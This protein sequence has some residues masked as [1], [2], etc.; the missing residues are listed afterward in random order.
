ME[1]DSDNSSVGSEDSLADPDS[2]DNAVRSIFASYYG[3]E[4]EQQQQQQ[5]GRA[6]NGAAAAADINSV[7][8]DADAYSKSLLQNAPIE[9]LLSRDTKMTHEIRALDSDMQMLVYENYN[10]FI[11]ATETIKRMKSNV[12]AMD[13]DMETVRVKMEAITKSALQL[14]ESLAP[15]NVK[16][17]K[18]TRVRRVLERLEFLSELPEK[19]ASMIHKEDYQR[20]VHLYRRTIHVL[21]Q[22][23]Q[24]LSFRKIKERTEAMMADL[25]EH[26]TNLLEDPNLEAVK[27]TQYASILRL[28]EANRQQV[29]SRLLQAHR[30]RSLRMIRT[31]T[32]EGQSAAAAAAAAASGQRLG[33]AADR[34]RQF[35]QGLIVGI[36]EACKGLHELYTAAQHVANGGG[37]GGGVSNGGGAA[38]PKE[39]PPSPEEIKLAAQQFNALL[40][41]VFPAY[42]TC[43]VS[44]TNAFFDRYNKQAASSSQLQLFELDDERQAWIMLV[45][46]TILD[47]QFCDKEALQGLMNLQ[48][49]VGLG[50]EVAVKPVA[51]GNEYA[52]TML[53]VLEAHMQQCVRRRVDTF[54][55]SLRVAVSELSASLSVVLRSRSSFPGGLADQCRTTCASLVDAALQNL[56]D[57]CSDAKE[58]VDVY[59][60]AGGGGEAD[61]L[62]HSWVACICQASEDAAAAAADVAT[63][64]G[65]NEAN[66]L[67]SLVVYCVL[68]AMNSTN[69]GARA[70]KEWSA[71]LGGRWA[72]AGG[73]FQT[74]ANNALQS[75]VEFH[76]QRCAGICAG[77]CSAAASS[78]SSSTSSE[79]HVSSRMIDLVLDID[80]LA[81]TCCIVLGENPTTAFSKVCSSLRL[82]ELHPQIMSHPS[83]PSTT[84]YRPMTTPDAQRRLSAPSPTGPDNSSVTLTASLPSASSCLEAAAKATPLL[85]W[86]SAPSSRRLSRQPS[87]WRAHEA[88]GA[89]ALS[90][91]PQISPFSKSAPLACLVGQDLLPS[92]SRGSQRHNPPR[93]K[94]STPFTSSFSSPSAL[95]ATE[96]LPN[97]PTRFKRLSTP[98]ATRPSQ[99]SV[100]D[101]V[102]SACQPEDA[103][104]LVRM[105]LHSEWSC[106]ASEASEHTG[107]VFGVS[108]H[109]LPSSPHHVVQ[110]PD[111]MIDRHK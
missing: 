66:G 101:C 32:E 44:A 28:M 109:S 85:T 111:T 11:S 23:S 71:A 110:S 50:G 3:I 88:F 79:A 91:S 106:L 53:F 75:L 63:V 78:S 108:P 104:Q 20:A 59:S 47:C 56:S 12:D 105:G 80:R 45:R 96:P 69:F 62:A 92:T 52:K 65:G 25:R 22:H 86:S 49:G 60:S 102:C 24:V 77:I 29:C 100:F 36:I 43:L 93:S 1:D 57:V 5:H 34:A 35:H 54:C 76:A 58:I 2:T 13:G 40:K 107:S 94:T 15:T 41:D 33:S 10:K 51:Y 82:S 7:H 84:N 19:L 87:K 68:C 90:K 98:F 38:L 6:A 30:Q 39:E 83:F 21:T 61:E 18:L 9:E 42:K 74:A 46:Q 4:Q 73:R 8:F 67:T 64:N 31:F 97:L 27:L 95:A 16:I 37:G 17:D 14:D 70:S 89:V 103:F 72:G 81:A 48:G 55:A 99:S 26:V